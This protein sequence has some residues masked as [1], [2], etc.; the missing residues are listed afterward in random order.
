MME[1]LDQS[2]FPKLLYAPITDTGLS[3]DTSNS[4]MSPSLEEANAPPNG[5][6]CIYG[7]GSASI[8][9]SDYIQTLR[10]LITSDYSTA[11]TI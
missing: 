5:N 11:D 1:R 6:K 2:L 3:R 9:M 8:S 7:S 10:T 4:A